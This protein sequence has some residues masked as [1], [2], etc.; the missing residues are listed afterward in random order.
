MDDD[1]T[2]QETNDEDYEG[3]EDADEAGWYN[4]I[5]DDA[6]PDSFDEPGKDAPDEDLGGAY[7][8]FVQARRCLLGLRKARG[9]VP[10]GAPRDPENALAPDL[11]QPAKAR[12][13]ARAGA[14][15]PAR[16]SLATAKAAGQVARTAAMGAGRDARA[17]RAAARASVCQLP[18]R[19]LHPRCHGLLTPRRG[20]RPGL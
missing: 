10:I 11:P 13:D 7:V 8:S 2:G 12:S 5:E 3:A 1:Y 20:L 6:R 19:R 9:F 17:P 4:D 18:L 16:G 14:R 15:V